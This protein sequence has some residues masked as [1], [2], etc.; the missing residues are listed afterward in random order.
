LSFEFFSPVSPHYL[1]NNSNNVNKNAFDDFYTIIDEELIRVKE[2]LSIIKNQE[3]KRDVEKV[4]Q[5]FQSLKLIKIPEN[6][7]K[8]RKRHLSWLSPADVESAHKVRSLSAK[9]DKYD[10]KIA[11]YN[12]KINYYNNKYQETQSKISLALFN[13]FSALKNLMVKAVKAFEAQI[14]AATTTTTTTIAKSSTTEA[15][16]TTAVVPSSSSSSFQT[17]TPSPAEAPTTSPQPPPKNDLSPPPA[18]TTTPRASG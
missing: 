18:Q 17:T 8:R 5:N 6:H 15:A 7:P 12:T 10:A 9:I 3:E 2:L 1:A 11:T 4:I 14:G 16:T 13:A